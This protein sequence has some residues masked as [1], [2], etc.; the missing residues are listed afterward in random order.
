MTALRSRAPG[1]LAAPDR[2]EPALGHETLHL[3]HALRVPWGDEQDE[4]G[5]ARA[6]PREGVQHGGV[7]A[8]MRAARDPHEVIFA[9]P[10]QPLPQRLAAGIRGARSV[11]RLPVTTTRSGGA[12]R[13]MMRRASSCDC[14]AKT[15]TSRSIR[16]VRKRT[17]R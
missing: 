17:R 4:L 8:A 15:P 11:L 9:E 16:E 1:E 7:L 10:E 3:R 14:I 12:P 5:E 13:A 2:D 6:E